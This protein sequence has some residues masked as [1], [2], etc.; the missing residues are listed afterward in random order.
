MVAGEPALAQVTNT[1]SARKNTIWKSVVFLSQTSFQANFF[2]LPILASGPAFNRLP[3]ACSLLLSLVRLQPLVPR[4]AVCDE[5]NQ[6]VAESLKKGSKK[7]Q[8]FSEGSLGSGHA[9]SKTTVFWS[10]LVG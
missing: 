7:S 5:A 8:N 2:L 4:R 1:P 3:H 6:E 10:V 9:G